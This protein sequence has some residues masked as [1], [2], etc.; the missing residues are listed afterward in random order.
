[1]TVKNFFFFFNVELGYLFLSDFDDLRLMVPSLPP[2]SWHHQLHWGTPQVS[3]FLHI[4]HTE[5]VLQP[6]LSFPSCP[7]PFSSFHGKG[8]NLCERLGYACLSPPWKLKNLNSTSP[9]MKR[10]QSRFEPSPSWSENPWVRKDCI[11]GYK[12]L[13]SCDKAVKGILMYTLESDTG[14]LFSS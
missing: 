11:W 10:I 12:P 2:G 3:W 8:L 1:M 14:F 6:V 4:K 13:C 9:K 7:P 5:A